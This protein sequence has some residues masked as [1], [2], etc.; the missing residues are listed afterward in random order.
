MIIFPFSLTKGSRSDLT[1]VVEQSPL[2]TSITQE[3]W[4]VEYSKSLLN[5]PQLMLLYQ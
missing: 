3:I 4:Y 5:F 1:Q 2:Y